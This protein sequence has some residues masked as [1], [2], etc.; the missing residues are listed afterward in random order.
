VADLRSAVRA[1]SIGDSATRQCRRL[2]Q[3]ASINQLLDKATGWGY[4][5]NQVIDVSTDEHPPG[6]GKADRRRALVAAAYRRIA[7]DGFEG[8]RTRDIAS[9]V[10]VNIATLHYYFPSKE[11]LIRSVIGFAIHRFTQTMPGDGSPLEQLRGHLRALARLLKEDQQLW[12]V[13]GELV[14][15]APRDAELGRIFRQTDGYWHRTLR[16][17]IGRCIEQGA[18]D[19]TLDPDDAAAL[20]I[21]AIKGL[22]LPTVA[23]FEPQVI[24]QVFRQFARLLGLPDLDP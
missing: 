3:A 9:D 8:L 2:R 18:V 22:S 21:A 17:L 15:R 10:G 20:M 23:G 19:A 14:L 4:P 16:E 7:S 1:A 24:D 13:M 12:A 6:G 11:A 5:T